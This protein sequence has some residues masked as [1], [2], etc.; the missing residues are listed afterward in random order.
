MSESLP[1]PR[2]NGG[3]PR[4]ALTSP[5]APPRTGASRPVHLLAL[6]AKS[7]EELKATADQYACLL[8][9]IS[10][11]EAP[12]AEDLCFS[13]ASALASSGHRLAVLGKTNAELAAKLRQWAAGQACAGV[14]QG[15]CESTTPPRIAFLFTGQGSQYRQMGRDLWESQPVF[16]A[17]LEQCD[18]IL[19]PRMSASL[20]DLIYGQAT[21]EERLHQTLHTQPV[22]FAFGYALARM[23]ESWGITPSFVLGHS[24]GELAAACF[25][26]VMSLEDALGLVSLR[27]RLIHHAT[28]PGMMGAIVAPAESVA[29]AL[30]ELGGEVEI[31]A[32]NG[33][34]NVVV[35]GAKADVQRVLEHFKDRDIPAMPLRISHAVHSH[36]M[37]PILNDYTAAVARMPLSLPRMPLISNLS[38]R[39]ADREITRPDYWRRQMRETVNFRAC[40]ESLREE[41]CQIALETGGTS[42]L[43]SLGPQCLPRS[44]MVWLHSLGLKNSM[45]N[46]RPQRVPGRDDWETLLETLGQLYCLGAAL[47]WNQIQRRV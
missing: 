28:S 2:E 22:I 21:P 6:S 10:A 33:P 18:A 36:L 31:A 12:N 9:G 46:M 38:G 15:R 47:D 35:S 16:R 1:I 41:G 3:Q 23:W 20:I 40:L 8:E 17:V 45:F 29:A 7:P 39:V 24:I 26:G 5:P 4:P 11:A 34:E 14:W 13:A 32:I 42:I 19:Q 27:G 44:N 30:K 37:E 25:A 43:A